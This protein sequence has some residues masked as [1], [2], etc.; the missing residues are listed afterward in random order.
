MRRLW[1]RPANPASRPAVETVIFAMRADGTDVRQ[2][3][4]NKWEDSGAVCVP[5]GGGHEQ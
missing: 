3:T 2:L 1:K 4:D 5:E